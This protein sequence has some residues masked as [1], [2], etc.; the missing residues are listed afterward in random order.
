MFPDLPWTRLVN[1]A[2]GEL[3][4]AFYGVEP[5]LDLAAVEPRESDRR[6][7]VGTRLPEGKPIA[8]ASRA[9]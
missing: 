5:A 9:A 1:S 8:I 6:Y 7:R 2:S 3:R 4:R